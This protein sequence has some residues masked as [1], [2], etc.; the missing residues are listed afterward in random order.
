MI[1]PGPVGVPAGGGPY[2]PRGG[3]TGIGDG[4]TGIGDGTGVV[5]DLVGRGPVSGSR[6]GRSARSRAPAPQ[7]LSPTG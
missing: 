4:D 5:N 3:D 2:R 1:V 6:G 7:A